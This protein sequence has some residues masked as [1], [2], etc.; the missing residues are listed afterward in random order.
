MQLSTV[1]A[2]HDAIVSE[3]MLPAEET[4]LTVFVQPSTDQGD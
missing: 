4:E 3:R 1:N 2:L